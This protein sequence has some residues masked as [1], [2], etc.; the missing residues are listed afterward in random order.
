M[1]LI[2]RDGELADKVWAAW[3]N[4]LISES[5]ARLKWQ[6]IA[7]ALPDAGDYSQVC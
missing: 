5:V 1:E 7:R 6:A 4:G 3:D 2:S